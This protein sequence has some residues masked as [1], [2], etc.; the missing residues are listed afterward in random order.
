MK[1]KNSRENLVKNMRF[2]RANLERGLGGSQDGRLRSLIADLVLV[3]I[4][5]HRSNVEYVEVDYTFPDQQ[6]HQPKGAGLWLP[7]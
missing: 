3:E 6:K 5:L 7:N 1:L 2:W 4:M